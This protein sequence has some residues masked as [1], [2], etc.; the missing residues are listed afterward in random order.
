MTNE[1]KLS[2]LLDTIGFAPS[3]DLP[4]IFAA[5]SVEAYSRGEGEALMHRCIH[6]MRSLDEDGFSFDKWRTAFNEA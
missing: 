3:D 6:A 2:R 1:Q 5:V 4:S